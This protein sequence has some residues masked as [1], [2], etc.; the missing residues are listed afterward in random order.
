MRIAIVIAGALV[1]YAINPELWQAIT[2]PGL[3][4]VL[5][6]FGFALLAMDLVADFGQER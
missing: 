5:G 1:A 3:F 4:V 2:S 6:L